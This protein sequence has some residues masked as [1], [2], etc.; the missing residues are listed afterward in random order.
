MSGA[1]KI[2]VAPLP[3]EGLVDAIE[4][5]GGVVAEPR[6]ADGIVW[7]DPEDPEGLKIVL[8]ESPARWIQLPFAGIER[9]VDAG[10]IGGG[11]T[12][13]SAKG[14]YGHATAEHALALMLTAARR[15]HEHVV[16]TSWRPRT[17]RDPER[18]LA[19]QTVLIVGTGGIGRELA[20]MLAPLDVRVLAVNRSGAGMPGAQR[21]EPSSRLRE[22]LPRADYVVVAAALT[23]E[24]AGLLG[25]DELRAMKKDAW[26]INVARGRIVQT[27]ALVR[28]LQEGE[29]G[30]AALDVT[31]PEPLPEGHPLW[32]LSNCVITPHV[33]NT[34]SMSLQAL[35]VL[36]QENVERL[37]AGRPLKGL[38]DPELGY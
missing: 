17:A 12:F 2:A 3:D 31:D 15:I 10:V 29:I 35:R 33:A 24:T 18:R 27:D 23:S 6:D 9:F 16:A 37:R 5:A 30:G 1:V 19:G 38:V 4:A 28:A 36:V 22:L 11:R 34:W 26:L 25:P 21:T 7:T 13:T 32:S 8:R 20:R 14:I